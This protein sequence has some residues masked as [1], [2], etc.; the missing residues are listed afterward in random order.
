MNAANVLCFNRSFAFQKG[1][2][3][4]PDTAEVSNINDESSRLARNP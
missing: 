3:A 4:A 1:L 2:L